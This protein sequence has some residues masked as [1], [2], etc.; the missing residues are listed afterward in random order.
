M[1]DYAITKD[2]LR[3]LVQT[4]PPV[5]DSHALIIQAMQRH[6]QLY[7]MDLYSFVASDDPIQ[8][9]HASIGQRLLGIDTI[10]PTRRVP[11]QNVRGQTSENQEWRRK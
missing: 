6:P 1:K 4:M 7:T 8:Q 10:E 9:L 3:E 5:F 11:S 2:L